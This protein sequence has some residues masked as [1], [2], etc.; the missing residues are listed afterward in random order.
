MK[1]K[2]NRSGKA[3]K[4]TRKGP[5]KAKRLRRERKQ[6][7][8]GQPRGRRPAPQVRGAGPSVRNV[9]WRDVEGGACRKCGANKHQVA[10]AVTWEYWI[11]GE[12]RQAIRLRCDKHAR[13]LK[14][15]LSGARP[16]GE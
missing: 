5:P 6:V 15:Q 1:T 8:A 4:V 2:R 16:Q 9:E 10:K 14:H 3:L 7:P 12:W 11:R 13:S